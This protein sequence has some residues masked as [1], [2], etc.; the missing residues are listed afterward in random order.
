MGFKMKEFS[1]KKRLHLL[2]WFVFYISLALFF[3]YIGVESVQEYLAFPKAL[4]Y[5]SGV[6]FLVFFPMLTLPI[7]SL[8]IYPIFKGVKAPDCYAR[9]SIRII[10]CSLLIC[11]TTSFSFKI[12][13]TNKLKDKGYISCQGIPNGWMPGMATKYALNENLCKK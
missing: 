3:L 11:I 5:S 10:I 13:Y 6:L 9:N 12:T 2:V 7:T 4:T 8:A 1:A